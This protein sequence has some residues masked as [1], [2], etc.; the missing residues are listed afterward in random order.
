VPHILHIVKD[1]GNASA[2]EVIRAQADQPGVTLYVVLTQDAGRLATSL[3]GQVYRMQDG[4]AD[5]SA[6]P[7][8]IGPA[9]LLELIFAADS[10]VTW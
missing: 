5:P 1:P 7:D 10:V 3:P 4:H 8:T 6:G 2:L 9:R